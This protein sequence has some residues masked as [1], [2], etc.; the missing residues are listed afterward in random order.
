MAPAVQVALQDANGNTVTSSTANVTLTVSAGPGGSTL[1]GT[2]TQTAVAG[3]ATFNNL[4]LTP[5]SA[6]YQITASSPSVTSAVSPTFTITATATSPIKLGFLTQPSNVA[7]GSTITPSIQVAVQDANGATV[8]TSNASITLALNSNSGG[9]T[10]SG[11][12][13]VGATN[14][15][16]TFTSVLVGLA[17]TGYTLAATAPAAGLTAATSTA[18]NVTPGTASHVAFV[19]QPATEVAGVPFSPDLQVAILDQAGNT[20]T[21]ATNVITLNLNNNPG[22]SSLAGTTSLA[23]VNGIATF[24]GVRLTKTGAG[25]TLFANSTSLGGQTSTSFDVTPAPAIALGFKN[26][27]TRVAAGASQPAPYI[28]VAVVDSL[29]NVTGGTDQISLV[30]NSV[31]TN[32]AIIVTSPV[33]AVAGVATFSDAKFNVSGCYTLAATAAN[34]ATVISNTF[35]IAAGPAAALKWV[36]NPTTAVKNGPITGNQSTSR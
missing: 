27:P 24:P 29:G 22:N 31:P 30:T 6:A 5:A 28:Q 34:L 19:V 35:C 15:V 18:F 7:S 36:N 20:V 17:G 9:A 13:T 25:Y 3:V 14:G 12:L 2:V 4:T 21:S 32:G 26:P 11:V 10:A 16:A 23:A 8:T 33:A 1:G